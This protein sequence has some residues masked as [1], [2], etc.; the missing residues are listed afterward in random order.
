MELTDQRRAFELVVANVNDI[1]ASCGVGEARTIRPAADETTSETLREP[2]LPGTLI[3]PSAGPICEATD[4]EEGAFTSAEWEVHEAHCVVS[5]L[6][7]PSRNSASRG[8]S[9]SPSGGKS[10]KSP[11]RGPSRLQPQDP[12]KTPQEEFMNRLEVRLL[13]S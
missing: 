10:R 2:Y 13:F 5:E 11:S 9:V 6:I 1:G 7:S 4:T 8:A 12:G 3:S